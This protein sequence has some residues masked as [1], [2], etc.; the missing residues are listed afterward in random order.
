MSP[1]A[2]DLVILAGWVVG[3]S[4]VA[5]LIQ[6]GGPLDDPVEDA[7][8]RYDL[9]RQYAGPAERCDAALE[10]ELAALDAGDAETYK[11]WHST[12]LADCFIASRPVIGS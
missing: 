9:A 12:R 3:M 7:R 10:V 1:R 4:A 11:L 8:E 2:K 6:P 5:Y